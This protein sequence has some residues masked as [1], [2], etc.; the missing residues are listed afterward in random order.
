MFIVI[1]ISIKKVFTPE[2]GEEGHEVRI[3]FPLFIKFT[4]HLL[5]REALLLI[6]IHVGAEVELGLEIANL[7]VARAAD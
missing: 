1:S 3:K 5:N 6:K 7:V 4:H 2:V